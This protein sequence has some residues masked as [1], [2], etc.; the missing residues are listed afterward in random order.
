[1][2]S[3][4]IQG[5]TAWTDADGNIHIDTWT[6]PRPQP[7]LAG[8][9]PCSECRTAVNLSERPSGLCWRCERN[10]AHL[11]EERPVNEPNSQ[12]RPTRAMREAHNGE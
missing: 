2:P 4:L 3:D 1:M 5:S 11:F 6:M 9:W 8:C 12:A 10:L 7:S